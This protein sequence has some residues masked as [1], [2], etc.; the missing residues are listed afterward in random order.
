M[1]DKLCVSN[2]QSQKQ[3]ELNLSEGVNVIRGRSDSGKS[4]IIR[5]IRWL[6]SNKPSGFSFKSDWL[7]KKDD[8]TFVQVEKD[9]KIITRERGNIFNGYTIKDIKS[10][11]GIVF[12]AMGSDVPNEVLGLLNLNEVNI[13]SQHD[14][15]FLLQNSSGEVAKKL[16]KVVGLDI[17]D[18]TLS[19]INSIVNESNRQAVST[20]NECVAKEQELRSYDGLDEIGEKINALDL[21]YDE[22][23][24]VE[25]LITILE[26][27]ISN[28]EQNTETLKDLDDW[29]EIESSFL[30]LKEKVDKII[31]VDN[32]IEVLET[33]IGNIE[34]FELAIENWDEEVEDL[35]EKYSKLLMSLKVCPL[36]KQKIG[37]KRHA[38]I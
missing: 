18:K 36:C 37:G 16:N 22:I 33:Y 30:I 11:E 27:C 34:S 8:P 19:K 23:G 26:T 15:Y 12:E 31:E 10:Q 38:R 3:T 32:L 35:Q 20:T 21:L 2:F 29:L 13:Q 9:G 6:L 1:W 14:R 7:K 28:I 25:R 5:A 17:I 4:S 24:E